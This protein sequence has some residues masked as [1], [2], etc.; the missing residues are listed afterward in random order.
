MAGRP[1]R[2][3]LIEQFLA[4]GITCM[5]GNPGTVEQGF[6]DAL[7]RYPDMRYVLSLQESVAVMMADGYAR[8]TRRPALVQIHSTPGLG[9]SIG[10]LYQAMRGHAPL[11]V[12]GGDAGLKYLPMQAQMYGDLVGMAEPVTKWSAMVTDESSLL[13]MV[14]RAVKIAAT[15]PMGPVYLC[16]PADV[17]DRDC[18]EP[19]EPS[20]KNFPRVAPDEATL[21]D[22]ARMLAAASRPILFIGD[23]VAYSG[24][25]A[26]VERIAEILGAEIWGVD[27]GELN[28]SCGHQLYKGQTGHMFGEASHPVTSKGDVNL[29]VGTYM[30]PEV[31]PK[32]TDIYAAEAKVIHIDLDPSAIAR[33]HR[34]TIGAVA[35]P[36]LSLD[37]LIAVL[38]KTMDPAQRS[39][40]KERAENIGA[41][42]AQS[43]AA[44]KKNDRA[45]RDEAVPS[46]ARFMEELVGALPQDAVVFDEALTCSP[47]L[48]R[49]LL[50]GTPG[51]F[52][53]TRGGSLGVGFPG[54]I[55]AK[56]ARPKQTVV[57]FSG[58]GGSMYTI[59]AL[60][61]AARYGIDVKFV[62]CNNGGYK[63][64][65]LN[66][67]QYWKEQG[68]GAHRFPDPFEL[69]GPVVDFVTLARSMGVAG[70]KIDRAGQI[71]PA[72]KTMLT[73]SGPFLI[74]L[75][76]APNVA[77]EIK[78]C[79]CGQ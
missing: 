54:A 1:G 66:I 68:I 39:R 65:K 47:E 22:M 62:V 23:G 6:L 77:G 31:Y 79:R 29:V 19:V 15:P 55:G 25:Q 78:E 43:L 61:T 75:A 71:G 40:A 13:R 16:L 11:V 7:R 24:A 38:E 76:V 52:F 69:T 72:I 63:L 73:T 42:T 74:D 51:N 10:A 35:D 26:E 57:G 53:Q 18:D 30:V 2:D 28:A 49:Y 5:F 36:K 17:L 9:N 12:I 21:A 50:P 46:T 67:Q 20:F 45:H 37:R 4:D 14:R 70:V 64:L 34:V 60:W 58:D 33:N 3:A 41:E 48:I 56:L 8:A 59:Q 32:L 44:Q 27:S